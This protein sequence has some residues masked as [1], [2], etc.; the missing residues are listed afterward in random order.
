MTRKRLD[1]YDLVPVFSTIVVENWVFVKE[2]RRKKKEPRSRT[3]KKLGE[4][5]AFAAKKKDRIA[6]LLRVLR[7]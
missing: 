6:V 2:H 5:G 4:L 7:G 1:F 3:P